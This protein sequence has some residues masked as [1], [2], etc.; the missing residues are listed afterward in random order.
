[1]RLIRTVMAGSNFSPGSAWESSWPLAAWATT[2]TEI[3]HDTQYKK[4]P[5]EIGDLWC[6]IPRWRKSWPGKARCVLR[7]AGSFGNDADS[8]SMS[9]AG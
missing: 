4:T 7:Q 2:N 1:M 8:V 6:F 5:E 9:R 3:A